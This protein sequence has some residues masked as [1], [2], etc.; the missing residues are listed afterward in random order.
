MSSVG[1][2]Y[3]QIP[4]IASFAVKVPATYGGDMFLQSD[5]DAWYANN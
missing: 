2:G 5:I 3:A 1:R 4:P